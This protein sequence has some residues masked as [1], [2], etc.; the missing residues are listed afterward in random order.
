MTMT[1]HTTTFDRLRKTKNEGTEYWSARD[2]MAHLGYGKWQNFYEAI[3][4]AESTC[5]VSG[6]NIAD[7]F[8]AAS[9]MVDIG[10]G[11]SRDVLDY[12]LSRYAAYLVAMNGDT[13]KPEVAAA[14]TYFAVKARQAEVQDQKALS[15][16]QDPVLAQLQV[17]Q[18]VRL[19]QLQ[20][21]TKV[22]QLELRLDDISI[23]R[24]QT[25]ALLDLGRRL[26]RAMGNNYQ[27]A[28]SLFNNHFGLA[29]YRDLPAL[30]FDEAVYFLEH[31]VMA[32][33]PPVPEM[34]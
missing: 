32:Y 13:R 26:G 7:H 14:Q 16:H 18:E 4:K 27:K 29:S 21:E 15:F 2:L 23:N 22:E 11:A 31:Q 25:K 10:S 8:T 17:M 5:E 34:P 9:K 12:H 33:E 3:K 28:W 20:L 24:A 19:S 1:P 6:H 30:K